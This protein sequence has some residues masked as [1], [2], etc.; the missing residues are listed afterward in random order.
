MIT[1]QEVASRKWYFSCKWPQVIEVCYQATLEN[2]VS[3][4]DNGQVCT[5]ILKGNFQFLLRNS[6]KERYDFICWYIFN[7][8]KDK[9]NSIPRWPKRTGYVRK[10][11]IYYSNNARILHF[12]TTHFLK[13]G[14]FILGISKL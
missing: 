8:L 7:V 12:C 6:T 11:G 9:K 13:K 3:C 10:I 14:L 2:T 1:G 4:R 5:S